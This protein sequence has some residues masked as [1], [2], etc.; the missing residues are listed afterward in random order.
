MNKNSAK[1]VY[2]SSAKHGLYEEANFDR[3]EIRKVLHMTL[4]DFEFAK[5][6]KKDK[7]PSWRVIFNAY[8]DVFR[9]LCD[10]LMRFKKHKSSNH[11]AVFAFIA[12]HFKELDLEWELLE[13]IRNVRNNNKYKALDI[14]ERMWKSV[15]MQ[16]EIYIATVKKEVEKRV[17]EL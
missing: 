10:Q 13:Q 11:Q 4:E 16:F 6:V 1:E 8:Y 9:E 12:T 5:R 14:T 17:G 2:E 7:N 15:E 3:E